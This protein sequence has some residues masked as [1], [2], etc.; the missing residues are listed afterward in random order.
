MATS[1]S[2]PRI[3]E[4][5]DDH[6]GVTD[7]AYRAR[8]AAIAEVAEL[9][10]RPEAIPDVEYSPEEDGVWRI[11]SSELAVKHETY[12]CSAYR[13]AARRLVLPTDRVPQLREV[14]ERLS[15]LTGF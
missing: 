11:V 6:P 1:R 8:R 14:D 7:L 3:L 9:Y 13:D 15:A 2:E 12:A 5:P 10:S 4:L